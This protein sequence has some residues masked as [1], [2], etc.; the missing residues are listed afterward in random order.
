MGAMRP[1][2]GKLW[3]VTGEREIEVLRR[4][5]VLA[6]NEYGKGWTGVIARSR[7]EAREKFRNYQSLCSESGRNLLEEGEVLL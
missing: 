1:K 7:A 6:G 5:V 3:V 2:V 4:P